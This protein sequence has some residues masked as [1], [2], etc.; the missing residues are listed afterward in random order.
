MNGRFPRYDDQAIFW[1]VIREIQHPPV[2][3]IQQ[4]R[5][6]SHTKDLLFDSNTTER[7][8]VT[9]MLDPCIFSGGMVSHHTSIS[10]STLSSSSLLRLI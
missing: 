10:K 5:D 8:L 7:Y 9:C 2:L 4:C 3:H 6:Y 1:T